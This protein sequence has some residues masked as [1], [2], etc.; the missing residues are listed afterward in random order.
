MHTQMSQMDA[1][2]SAEDLID[3]AAYW[4]HK[5]VAITDHG[6]VQSYPNGMH[7]KA[8]NPDIKVIYGLEGYLIDDTKQITYGITYQKTPSEQRNR[9]HHPDLTVFSSATAA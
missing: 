3:R 1:V 2:N 5:A 4:G 8:A 9:E 6:V 7:G